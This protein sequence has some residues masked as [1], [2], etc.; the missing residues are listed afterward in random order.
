MSMSVR[1]ASRH[2]TDDGTDV[3]SDKIVKR[4]TFHFTTVSVKPFDT[5][6]GHAH[7]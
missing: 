5:F 1:T 7:K 3:L 6:N 2:D 4:A